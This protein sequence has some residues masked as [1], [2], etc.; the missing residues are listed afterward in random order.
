MASRSFYDYFRA[1]TPIDVIERMQ[2]G[3][4][5]C[6]VPSGVPSTSLAR[7]PLGVCVDATRHMLP[8]WYGAGAGLAA[9]RK[10]FGFDRVRAGAYTEWFFLR[11]LDRRRG[12][13][14]GPRRSGY[15]QRVQRARARSRCGGSLRRFGRNMPGRGIR[16]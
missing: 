13:D 15:R 14:A 1:V 8:G 16:F 7:G 6:I 2:I 10:R 11:N 5:P 3:S 12:S 4:R 9:A